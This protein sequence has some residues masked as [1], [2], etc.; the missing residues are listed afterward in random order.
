MRHSSA[1]ANSPRY[2]QPT[3][4]SEAKRSSAVRPGG[5]SMSSSPSSPSIQP[6]TSQEVERVRTQVHE[7]RRQETRLP[8]PAAARAQLASKLDEGSC[9]EEDKSEPEKS[10][11]RAG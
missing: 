8:S 3:V 5:P 4:A 11:P 10:P 7:R 1:V 6:L 9:I 2:M